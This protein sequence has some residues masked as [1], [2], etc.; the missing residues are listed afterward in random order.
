MMIWAQ[1]E[2]HLPS[3]Y[4]ETEVPKE[5]KSRFKVHMSIGMGKELPNIEFGTK[6]PLSLDETKLQNPSN[7]YLAVVTSVMDEFITFT[8]L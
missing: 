2:R 8:P 1:A 4:P 7:N 6:D 5:P 3:V